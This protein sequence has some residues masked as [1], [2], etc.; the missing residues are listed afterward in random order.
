[1]LFRSMIGCK[2]FAVPER[3]HSSNRVEGVNIFQACDHFV[4]IAT[5]EHSSE[6]A[7]AR[8]DFVWTRAVADDVPEIH[9]AIVGRSSGEARLQCFQVAMDVAEEEY[10]QWT[11]EWGL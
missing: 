1:M 4:M 9:D 6:F 7:Y 8:S 5:D 10:A 11:P 2:L 3:G